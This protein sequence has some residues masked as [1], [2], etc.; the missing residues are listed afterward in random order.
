MSR[1]ARSRSSRFNSGS[2]HRFDT[3]GTRPQRRPPAATPQNLVDV[4]AVLDLGR[5]RLNLCLVER[6]RA[7]LPLS[8]HFDHLPPGSSRRYLSRIG[9][10]G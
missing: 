3:G 1:A 4:V 5:E 10:D 2:R 8:R 7:R 6:V 9:I